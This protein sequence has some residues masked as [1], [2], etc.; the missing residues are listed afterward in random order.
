MSVYK[1]LND[2][3]SQSYTCLKLDCYFHLAFCEYPKIRNFEVLQL[4]Q[5]LY[6]KSSWINSYVSLNYEN[7]RGLPKCSFNTDVPDL[8][9]ISDWSLWRNPNLIRLQ[10][11][12]VTKIA[13]LFLPY[14]LLRKI[15][16][17][18][19]LHNISSSDSVIHLNEKKLKGEFI[20]KRCWERRFLKFIK[21]LSLQNPQIKKK[22][23]TFHI[24]L[25]KF[26]PEEQFKQ[27]Y[28]TSRN[29]LLPLQ[30]SPMSYRQR[31]SYIFIFYRADGLPTMNENAACFAG[32]PNYHAHFQ[33][34]FAGIK[35]MELW[36]F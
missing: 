32:S 25:L 5:K 27:N 30:S 6:C 9:K 16:F 12:C 22:S 35:V 15:W 1:R 4:S 28:L 8:S 19:S 18:S 14:P 26:C 29:L 11:Y 33:I 13:W 10:L 24:L 7:N 31:A 17:D 36:I 34:S 20:L 2:H 23:S 21:F 3:F